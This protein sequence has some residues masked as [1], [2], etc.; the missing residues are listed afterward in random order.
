MLSIASSV[1]WAIFKTT[2]YR[3]SISFRRTRACSWGCDEQW[4]SIVCLYAVS[5]FFLSLHMDWTIY[6][7]MLV[8]TYI[9]FSWTWIMVIRRWFKHR[10]DS[11]WEVIELESSQQRHN[12][13]VKV[14]SH[15]QFDANLKATNY[16]VTPLHLYQRDK[17]CCF[18]CDIQ[19]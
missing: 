11:R 3:I 4:T 12:L 15:I 5:H 16:I 14:V 9:L 8:E 1:A 6:C 13:F 10:W 17:T 2:T 19:M 7:L 18:M